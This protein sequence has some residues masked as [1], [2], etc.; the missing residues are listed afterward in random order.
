MV[1]KTAP[2]VIQRLKKLRNFSFFFAEVDVPKVD[3]APRS[4][5]VLFLFIA[6]LL[7]TTA[8]LKLSMLLTDPFADIRVQLPKK[9]L[10]LT[11]GFELWLAYLNFRVRKFHVIAFVDLVVFSVFGSLAGIRWTFGFTSCGCS[12]NLDLPVW[13]FMLL[14][15]GILFGLF[16]FSAF[17]RAIPMGYNELLSIYS[18]IP[19]HRKGQVAGLMA[20]VGILVLMEM[21]VFAPARIRILGASPISAT[22]LNS[23]NMTVGLPC[24]TKVS[25]I[26]RSKSSA[27]VVGLFKSCSC[28]VFETMP[29]FIPANS[30]WTTE[31]TI[32][33]KYV[34]NFH[35]RVVFFLDHPEQFRLKI[36]VLGNVLKGKP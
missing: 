31:I 4:L 32:T 13:F 3:Q 6:L 9:V 33:P 27:N 15:V 25:L 12:G 14:D 16:S 21:E 22:I 28:V 19:I 30:T 36:E 1:S 7:T 11:V 8:V 10:W 35:Q 34:G 20:A 26:N 29:I 24:R 5:K 17:R 2:N 23:G 18:R